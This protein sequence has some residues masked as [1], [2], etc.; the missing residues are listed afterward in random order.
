MLHLTL[1][2]KLSCV[3]SVPGVV[4]SPAV[5]GVLYVEINP[6]VEKITVINLIVLVISRR[7]GFWDFSMILAISGL[8]IRRGVQDIFG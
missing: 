1:P 5:V 2:R 4:C 8:E 6:A 7:A 3:A